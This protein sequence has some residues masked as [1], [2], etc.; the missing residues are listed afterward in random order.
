MKKSVG[1][2]ALIEYEGVLSAVLQVRGRHNVEKELREESWP[3]G[4]QVT[5]HGKAEQY[6]SLEQTLVREVN[7]EL[8]TLAAE[9]IRWAVDK[10]HI[11]LVYE[12]HKPEK[13]ILTY[14][15]V[16]PYEFV[17]AIRWHP[18]TGGL[19]LITEH[20]VVFIKDLTKYN[21]QTGVLNR[22]DI[23]MFPDEIEAI[24]KAF[25]IFGRQRETAS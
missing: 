25:Q 3:G 13:V 20:E 8:G 14:A 2:L 17:Q 19:R 23:A 9:H 16:L 5:V 21:K 24:Q 18:S 4:C 22:A 15:A 10:G 7:E 12:L 6:E 1:F 11:E